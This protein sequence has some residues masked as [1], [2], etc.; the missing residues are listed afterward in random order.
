LGLASCKLLKDYVAKYA[1]LKEVAILLKL[2][3]ADHELNIPYQGGISS[4]SLVLLIVAY[5][6]FYKLQQS[7]YL[8]PSRLLM[9]FLD[10]YGNSFQP[11]TF[12]INTIN[13]ESFYSLPMAQ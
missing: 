11:R 7:P 3:L 9:G 13:D 5:M 8:T 2:F 6:N 4:Y 1:C 12:G 10:F